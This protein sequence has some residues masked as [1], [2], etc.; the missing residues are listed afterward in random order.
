MIIP[1]RDLRHFQLF[2]IQIYPYNISEF[3]MTVCDLSSEF[4]GLFSSKILR[5]KLR[6]KKYIESAN[7]Y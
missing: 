7:K 4:P 3:K 2:S 1:S 5:H 6:F